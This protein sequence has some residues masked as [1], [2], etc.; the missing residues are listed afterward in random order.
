[1][2]AK[3]LIHPPLGKMRKVK[4]PSTSI[5]WLLPI[6]GSTMLMTQTFPHKSAFSLATKCHNM[7]YLVPN[8]EFSNRESS[9][10]LSNLKSVWR[11]SHDILKILLISILLWNCVSPST[12][13]VSHVAKI[14]L[15]YSTASL[16][17]LFY[18][19]YFKSLNCE[20]KGCA[21]QR[22]TIFVSALADLITWLW[23][24]EFAGC[25]DI[26]SL[27][28]SVMNLSTIV[29]VKCTSPSL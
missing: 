1:M 28:A 19:L 16:D 9:M 29:T 22:F 23:L 21:G 26:R 5:K 4:I 2:C 8:L 25:S 20:R 27:S 6:C 14:H 17:Y 10:G 7:L 15:E 13:K 11:F 12:S 24:E 18:D 3:F